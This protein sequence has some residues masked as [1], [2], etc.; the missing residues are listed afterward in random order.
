MC[1]FAM[2][3]AGGDA[4]QCEIERHN[5]PRLVGS[6]PGRCLLSFSVILLPLVILDRCDGV[7]FYGGICFLGEKQRQ[8]VV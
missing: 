8:T 4:K 3:A 6:Y 7:I 5:L 2:A 1:G